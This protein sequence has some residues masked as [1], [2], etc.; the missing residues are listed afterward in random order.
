MSKFQVPLTTIREV[1]N[2]PNADRLD[3]VKIYDWEVVTQRDKYKPNDI[4]LYIPV[5]SILPQELEE[6]IFPLGSKVKLSNHKVR[7]IKL[8]GQISQGMIVNP[9]DIL[10]YEQ[11]DKYLLEGDLSDELGIKKYEPE[12][13][14]M[15]AHMQT[16][17]PKQGV[18]HS[19]RKYSDIEN[20]KNYID[21]F[22]DGEEVYISEKL[23]GCLQ[24]ETRIRLL[25]GT[26]KR[27]KDIVD[28][29]LDVEIW[30]YDEQTKKLVPAKI[31]NWFNNGST[32]EWFDVRISN[33]KMNRGNHFKSVKATSNHKFFN[34]NTNQYIP[35]SELKA[36]DKVLCSRNYNELSFIQEQ[37]LIGKMLGDG[38]YRES[39][40]SFGHKLEHEKYII[41]TLE[42]L[43]DIAGKNTYHAISGYGTEML[44]GRTIALPSIQYLFENWITEK[45]KEV[46]EDII[47]KLTPISMAYWYMDDGNLSHT[48]D[49]NFQE[50][51]I[52]LATCGFN[53]QS[54]DNLLSALKNFSIKGIKYQSGEK[55]PYWRIRLNANDAEKFFVL[56]APYIHPV[57]R[58]KLPERYRS[59]PYVPI[60][61][62]TGK[63]QSK[64]MEQEIISITPVSKKRAQ[65]NKH[66]YDIETTTHNFIANDVVVHNSSFRTLWAPTE[67]NTLWKKILKLFGLLP[68]H[69]FCWGSRNVQIQTKGKHQ[70]FYEMDIY[71]KTV[72]Q[73]DLKNKIPKGYGVYGEIIGS[74]IQKGYTYGLGPGEHELYVYDIWS[75]KEK[76]WLNYEEFNAMVDTMGLKKVPKLYVGPYSKEIVDKLRSGDSTI[77][78]Q[79]VREGV[80]VKPVIEEMS[81][82]GRKI[83]K[84]ISDAYYL[85]QAE[86][87]GTEFH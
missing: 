36:G 29:K 17:S 1:R 34:P 59:M 75:H 54:I 14:T 61:G 46:P 19:F 81:T 32:D 15:P 72:N 30:G 2:H 47:G 42:A 7:S 53:E 39:S 51:R 13:K 4:V 21:I 58:Y 31:T 82:I 48:P 76:R 52:G 71:T 84:F 49:K 87:D 83:L 63:Y 27:I 12:E 64:L 45:G 5:D 68:E 6:K 50:D 55:A 43:G 41:D 78:G 73:Y 8:R 9:P 86:E 57:M 77:G 10:T 56:V 74:G 20:A 67:V 24:S 62:M 18:N 3:I 37:I 23:H 70:G 35:V 16:K 38:S 79:K 40:I 80:V 60:Q 44:R 28:N 11:L 22:K 85:K 66:K 26:F 25:D 69:E 65:F 33:V